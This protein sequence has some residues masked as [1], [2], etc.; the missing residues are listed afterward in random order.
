[1]AIL[2]G[3][4]EN[5]IVLLQ[6]G[7]VIGASLIAAVLDLRARRIPNLLCGPLFITGLI[8]AAWQGGVNGL[9]NAF[10]AGVLLA[11][12]FVILFIFA[13]GGA[14]DAKLMAAI[15]AWMGLER[16]II[17]I[18]CVCIA[19]GI[20]AI[21]TAIAKKRLKIVLANILLSIYSFIIAI[22]GKRGINE[23]AEMARPELMDK[24][25]IPYGIAIFA[26]VC[27]AAGIE[28]IWK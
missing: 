24:L 27:L 1:M 14:G 11:L 2:P 20:L 8:W 23:A 4:T 10:L 26:G 19:G 7:V 3:M 6:W 15:G 25:T 21:G 12:P 18:V 28:L 17:V 5:K 16:I 13:G 9:G 22:L